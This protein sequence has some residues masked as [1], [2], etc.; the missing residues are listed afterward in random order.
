M[1]IIG[2]W[3]PSGVGVFIVCIIRPNTTPAVRPAIAPAALGD[4]VVRLHD[5][6]LKTRLPDHSDF[7]SA[8]PLADQN[9]T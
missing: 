6:Q 4:G 3:P 2:I 5:A 9:S 1:A 7:R 8:Q